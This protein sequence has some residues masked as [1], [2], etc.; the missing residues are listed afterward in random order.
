MA[1]N[2]VVEFDIR[3]RTVL[4]ARDADGKW[5]RLEGQCLRCGKCCEDGNCPELKYE[6]LDGKPQASCKVEWSKPWRCAVY[7]NDPHQELHEGCGYWWE[8]E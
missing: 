5:W 3:A 2:V 7:P 8:A 6:T 1:A 4:R